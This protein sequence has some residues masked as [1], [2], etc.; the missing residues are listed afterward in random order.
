VYVWLDALS[1]YMASLDETHPDSREFI[2]VIGKDI[3]RFHCIYWPEFL[4]AAELNYPSK[5]LVHAH[6]LMNGVKMSKS[7]GNV[8]CPFELH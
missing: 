8:V 2:H 5:L 4:R 7:I 1:N 3:V 6:W